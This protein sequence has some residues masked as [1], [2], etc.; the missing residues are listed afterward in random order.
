MTE[1]SANLGFLW[2]ELTL[3]DAIRAA[4]K[5]GF[6][7]VEMHWPYDTLAAEVSAV[8][9]ETGLPLLGVNTRTVCAPC[10][11]GRRKRTP[12]SIRRLPMRT[13]LVQGRF[14]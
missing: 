9:E 3:P 7:A 2:K 8:L 1:F 10:R 6:S 4:K 12:P 11:D 13:Q 5:A 14:M